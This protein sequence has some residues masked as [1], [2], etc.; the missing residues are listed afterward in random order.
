M[1]KHWTTTAIKNGK[2]VTLYV[3]TT[4]ETIERDL[5]PGVGS[6][7][8]L[9]RDGRAPNPLKDD[10]HDLAAGA[11]VC[12]CDARE[13]RWADQS[14]QTCDSIPAGLESFWRGGAPGGNTF[15]AAVH[16]QP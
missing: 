4:D 9:I 7:I 12:H 15:T 14:V 1:I 13:L 8:G 2:P 5:A 6:L 3:T 16:E 10:H 11:F